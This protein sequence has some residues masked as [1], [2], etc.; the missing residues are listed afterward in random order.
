MVTDDEGSEH[1][2]E[3]KRRRVAEEPALR[4]VDFMTSLRN[5][6][7][8]ADAEISCRGQIFF[9]HRNIVCSM[10]G[11]LSE[12]L[13]RNENNRPRQE[14][15][16][17][18]EALEVFLDFAY[19]RDVAAGLQKDATLAC[20]VVSLA[21]HLEIP[22]LK[23]IAANAASSIVSVASAVKLH[24]MLQKGQCNS[25]AGDVFLYIAHRFEQVSG[26]PEFK[27]IDVEDL[28]KFVSSKELVATE[29]GLYVAVKNWLK[30]NRKWIE[31][32]KMSDI[33]AHINFQFMCLSDIRALQV[34]SDLLSKKVLWGALE[35][36]ASTETNVPTLGP[37]Q[38]N[39]PGIETV[40]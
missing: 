34:D 30:H 2:R 5:D 28:N 10:S 24:M 18:K 38:A 35:R 21:N 7:S 26:T 29:L 15:C 12:R 40:T 37:W 3:I 8:Y 6:P 13:L 31:S 22:R 33:F 4:P 25:Q 14:L 17:S 19:C 9:V 11:F 1:G 27:T 32:K 23:D 20:E 36:R 16:N 39:Q